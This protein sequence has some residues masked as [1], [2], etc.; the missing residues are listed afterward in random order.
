M[1]HGWLPGWVR[2]AMSAAALLVSVTGASAQQ[3]GGGNDNIEYPLWDV[4]AGLGVHYVDHHDLS[5]T[6][7]WWDMKAQTRLQFG[8]Y[9]T[10]HLKTEVS[11]AGPTTYDLSETE[12]F[13]AGGGPIAGW[14]HT[15]RTL[16][17][18]TVSPSLSYQFFENTFAH[19]FVSGG[20]DIS[21]GEDHRSRASSSYVVNRVAYP[22]TAI[23]TRETVMFA[24]PFIAAGFKSYFNDR[25]FVRP[26]VHTAFGSGGASQVSLRL[27]VGFDF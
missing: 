8:R 9:L 13:P 7:S 6:E 3:T 21:I 26:E 10:Q 5:P 22:V 12:F 11:A 19:P 14:A 20:V 16:K 4:S 15:E 27:D 18:F 1:R 25:A 2:S 23:D 24:R 17:V